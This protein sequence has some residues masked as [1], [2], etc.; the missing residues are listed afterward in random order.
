MKIKE[1]KIDAFGKFIYKN[2]EFKKGIN[3]IYGDNETGKSTIH[4]FIE[5][6]LFGI[7]PSNKEI[8]NKYQPWFSEEYK[9][10]LLMEEGENEYIINRDFNNNISSFNND[11]IKDSNPNSIEQPGYQLLGVNKEIYKNTLSIGQ[12]K[13]KTDRELL[14]EIKNK[15]ENLGKAKDENINIED[16][17]NRLEEKKEIERYEEI[18]EKINTLNNEKKEIEEKRG[19]LKNLVNQIL[20]NKKELKDLEIRNQFLE[21]LTSIEDFDELENKFLNAENIINEINTLNENIDSM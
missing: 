3:I 16:V 8:F 2:I 18:H 12:L 19:K 1:L 17:L 7:N 20:D 5:T 11:E 21:P 9:G 14:K 13:S 6:M 4:K 15:I 10:Q